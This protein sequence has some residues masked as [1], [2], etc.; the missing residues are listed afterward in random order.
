MLNSGTLNSEWKSLLV[1][2][3]LYNLNRIALSSRKTFDA[4]IAL[5]RK[6]RLVLTSS[7]KRNVLCF[8]R[9][10]NANPQITNSK[11]L[12]PRVRTNFRTCKFIVSPFFRSLFH[13]R[14]LRFKLR[15]R[16]ICDSFWSLKSTTSLPFKST[17]FLLSVDE[18]YRNEMT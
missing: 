3:L 15:H 1:V 5:Y 12:T 17:S 14:S 9:M 11:M 6:R 8:A 16:E 18:I 2:F 7:S 10:R 13:K 4:N